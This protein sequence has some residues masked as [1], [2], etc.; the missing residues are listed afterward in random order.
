MYYD[1][2]HSRWRMEPKEILEVMQAFLDNKKIQWIH[3][4]QYSPNRSGGWCNC[5]E[6]DWNFH[7]Y[8]FRVKP[9]PRDIWVIVHNDGC[10]TT[11]FDEK[12][13]QSYIMERTMLPRPPL[14][15][16]FKLQEVIHA[17]EVLK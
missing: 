17:K 13:A 1:K 12:A 10:R 15:P 4:D 3:V 5:N 8:L 11:F 16:E 14:T 7:D 6:P 2:N 9:E